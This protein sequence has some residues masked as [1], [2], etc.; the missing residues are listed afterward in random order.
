MECHWIMRVGFR[1]L[2]AIQ[3]AEY[4]EVSFTTVLPAW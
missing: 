1:M 3:R 2:I 4:V